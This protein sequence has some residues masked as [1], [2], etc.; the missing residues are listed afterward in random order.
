MSTPSDESVDRLADA[1]ERVANLEIELEQ[2]ANAGESIAKAL[3]RIPDQM[4]E[5]VAI[6]LQRSR[7][8]D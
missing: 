5:F 6:E 7:D 4:E 2:I 3:N 1:L 8:R